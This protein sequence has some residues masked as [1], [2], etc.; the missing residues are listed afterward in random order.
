MAAG[1][2]SAELDFIELGE[3]ELGESGLMVLDFAGPG[4]IGL[5]LTAP[6]FTGSGST[7][8]TGVFPDALLA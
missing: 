1:L 5:G 6:V 2:G 7:A 8:G 4:V 3:S